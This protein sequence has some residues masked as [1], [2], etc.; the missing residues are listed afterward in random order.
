[1]S[2]FFTVYKN[3]EGKKTEIKGIKGAEEAVKIIEKCIESYK[4]KFC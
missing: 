3:L 1:M 4:K 2:H